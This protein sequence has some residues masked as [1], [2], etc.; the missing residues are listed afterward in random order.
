MIPIKTT[1]VMGPK[2]HA[3]SP[4]LLPQPPKFQPYSFLSNLAPTHVGKPNSRT[5]KVSC[6][7]GRDR[8]TDEVLAAE[9]GR[10]IKKLNSNIAQR[11]EALK[12][13]REV[14]FAEVC[15]FTGLKSEDLKKKWKRMNE[16]EKWDLT[17]GFIAKWSAHFHPLSAKSVKE[18]VEEYVG[19][20]N[21]SSN[22]ASGKLFPDLRKLLGF[23]WDS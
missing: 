14:L 1:A 10:E 5:L 20:S 7:K 3:L 16:D 18:M 8:F 21:E 6:I 13:S 22:S 4:S 11:E 9:L 23:N 19:Q 17:K 15:N 12:K 2:I